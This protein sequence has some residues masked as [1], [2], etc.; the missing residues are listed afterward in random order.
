MHDSH[1]ENRSWLRSIDY[2]IGTNWPEQHRLTGLYVCALVT[3][4]GKLGKQTKSFFYPVDHAFGS[5]SKVG[6]RGTLNLSTWPY[7]EHPAAARTYRSN[8]LV[9]TSPRSTAFSDALSNPLVCFPLREIVASERLR[10]RASSLAKACG[11]WPSEP[12]QTI[13][14]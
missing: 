8:S 13:E 9:L 6:C 11:S 3:L 7:A 5:A 1:Y 4:S 2:Y 10:F 14:T 12:P